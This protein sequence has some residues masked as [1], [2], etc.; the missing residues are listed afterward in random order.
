MRRLSNKKAQVLYVMS[1]RGNG[2]IA[3]IAIGL[4]YQD[5]CAIEIDVRWRPKLRTLQEHD[6]DRFSFVIGDALE[7]MPQRLFDTVIM[8]NP[9]G[10]DKFEQ[11]IGLI[12]Q[13][14]RLPGTFV[15]INPEY[16]DLVL[17]VGYEETGSRSTG[18]HVEYKIFKRLE[19]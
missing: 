17:E 3:K 13:E 8:F 10:R 11:F 15:L 12:K 6:S 7:V 18:R 2:R 19:H 1:E 16:D 14:G 9:M 4:G 5:V